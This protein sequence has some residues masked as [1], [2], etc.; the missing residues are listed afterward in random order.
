MSRLGAG[1]NIVTAE[2]DGRPWGLTVSACASISM[3][4]PLI[5]MSTAN[6]T[7]RK[8]VILKSENFNIAILNEKQ[9]ETALAGAKSGQAKFFE[10]YMKYNRKGEYTLVKDALANINC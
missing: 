4:P 8:D 2:V 5:M 3:D 10:K 7:V 1:V 6:N 9:L